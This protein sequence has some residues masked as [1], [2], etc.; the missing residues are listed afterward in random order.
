MGTPG[1]Q[2]LQDLKQICLGQ[3]YFL[4]TTILSGSVFLFGRVKIE[5]KKKSLTCLKGDDQLEL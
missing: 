5:K 1:D 3:G 4:P 2:V